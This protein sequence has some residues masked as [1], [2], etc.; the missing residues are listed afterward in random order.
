[1]WTRSYFQK[2]GSGLILQ[3][4]N[5]QD[6]VERR[7]GVGVWV[8]GYCEFSEF[9]E[10]IKHSPKSLGKRTEPKHKE[11]A[12]NPPFVDRQYFLFPKALQVG[13][14]T[15]VNEG[16]VYPFLNEN[17]W[18]LLLCD[19]SDI[20][21]FVL[22]SLE[23]VSLWMN[24]TEIYRVLE[25]WISLGFCDMQYDYGYLSFENISF[26]VFSSFSFA[27]LGS[28]YCSCKRPPSFCLPQEMGQRALQLVK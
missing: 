9:C 8:W 14:F 24:Q 23:F 4:V 10:Y 16:Y 13:C 7:S 28:V 12:V 26:V 15:A 18:G 17:E 1:M 3:L 27:F 6:L 11:P 21:L 19:A 2:H 22:L 20:V 25:S 5:S